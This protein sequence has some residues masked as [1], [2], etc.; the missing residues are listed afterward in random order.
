MY[1]HLEEGCKDRR[2]HWVVSGDRTRGKVHKLEHGR[3]HQETLYFFYWTVSEVAQQGCG[4]SLPSWRYL[5]VACQMSIC[6]FLPCP[7]NIKPTWK[8]TCYIN[9][10]F[11]SCE[12]LC[13]SVSFNS[14]AKLRH[15]HA[16]LCCRKGG[17]KLPIPYGA[18]RGRVQYFPKAFS[19]WSI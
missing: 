15:H 14:E 2:L 9:K 10:I 8:S 17:S 5:Q 12:F 7:T 19:A 3:C 4:T 1:Q 18:Q 13:N 6:S 11:F 16:E